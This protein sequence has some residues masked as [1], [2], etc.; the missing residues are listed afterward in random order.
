MFVQFQQYQ[1]SVTIE[2]TSKL[3]LS[4]TRLNVTLGFNG[5]ISDSIITIATLM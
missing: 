1:S 2:Y 5:L 4:V 3:L